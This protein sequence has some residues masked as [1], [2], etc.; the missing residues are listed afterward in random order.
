MKLSASFLWSLGFIAM[1]HPAL[2]ASHAIESGVPTELWVGGDDGLTQRFAVTLRGA[3]DE[4]SDF[5]SN[6][7]ENSDRLLLT[8]PTHL[9]SRPAQGRTNFQYIVIFTDRNSYYLGISVG[10]CWEDSMERCALRVLSDARRAW[11]GRTRPN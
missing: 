1:W 10:S 9:Y 6:S 5:T 8:I 11:A 4:S 3:I 2:V 7:P